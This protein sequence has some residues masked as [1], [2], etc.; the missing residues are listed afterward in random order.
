MF[1]SET[2]YFGLLGKS[3]ILYIIVL[4]LFNFIILFFTYNCNFSYWAYVL[5]PQGGAGV[6]CPPFCDLMDPLYSHSSIF[7][8]MEIPV[9]S[10]AFCPGIAKGVWDRVRTS[11][12]LRI[13]RRA[14]LK[15]LIPAPSSHCRH[16]T[17]IL[18]TGTLDPRIHRFMAHT[19]FMATLLLT[20]LHILE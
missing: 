20:Y 3:Y 16:W 19:K 2:G 18:C 4:Y 17:L 11:S 13:S 14:Y 10:E 5:Y 15:W 1:W 7:C 9:Q 6:P 12:G 8:I